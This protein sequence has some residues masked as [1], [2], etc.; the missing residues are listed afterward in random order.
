[1]AGRVRQWLLDP[2]SIYQATSA[3][4]PEPST[5]QQLV[6]RA[7]PI[8]KQLSKLPPARTRAVLTALIERVEVRVDQI[9]IH[10]RQTRARLA[11]QSQ[12]CTVGERGNR[13]PVG[14]EGLRPRIDCRDDSDV[15][16]EHDRRR[17]QQGRS[18]AGGGSTGIESANRKR[19]YRRTAL[20]RVWQSELHPETGW[21]CATS[22]ARVS[23]QTG[24][25][26][27]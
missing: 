12:C 9:D 25:R 3:W 22:G 11:L 15:S 8:G 5:Q 2:G 20:S 18:P 1:V 16:S 4:I 10:L 6:A 23:S 19:G 21:R 26:R 14:T 17:G 13:D 24:S 7:A 27:P